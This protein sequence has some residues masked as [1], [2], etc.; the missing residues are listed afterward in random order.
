MRTGLANLVKVSVFNHFLIDRDSFLGILREFSENFQLYQSLCNSAATFLTS[1][2]I[3][4]H[5]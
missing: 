4:C 2:N 5:F 3:P 1:K